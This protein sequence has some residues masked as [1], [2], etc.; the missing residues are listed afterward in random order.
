MIIEHNREVADPADLKVGRWF[1][2]VVPSLQPSDYL[3]K[4]IKIDTLRNNIMLYSI[5]KDDFDRR[6]PHWFSV[7]SL[8]K[9]VS[10]VKSLYKLTEEEVKIVGVLE[11]KYPRLPL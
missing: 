9:V 4:V 8:A 6:S 1:F 2:K 11:K 5:P 3:C 7:E 10:G